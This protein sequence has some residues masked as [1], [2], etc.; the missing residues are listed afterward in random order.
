MATLKPQTDRIG[1]LVDDGADHRDDVSQALRD[2]LVTSMQEV[3]D[4]AE[5]HTLVAYLPR[6]AY[7]VG[8]YATPSNTVAAGAT[9]LSLDCEYDDGAGGADTALM[10]TFNG[11]VSTATADQTITFTQTAAHQQ[12]LIPAGSRIFVTSSQNGGGGGGNWEDTL[13]QL[14]LRYQ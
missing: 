10:T 9:S 14:H 12:T 1:V 3:T 11:T 5:E 2:Q 13:F 8:I 4:A 7:C 6:A